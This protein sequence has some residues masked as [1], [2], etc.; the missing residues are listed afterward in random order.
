MFGSGD[1]ANDWTNDQK[2]MPRPKARQPERALP[3]ARKS[4]IPLLRFYGLNHHEL[5][6]GALVHELDAAADFGKEGVVFAATN[7]EAGFHACAALT[8]DDRPTGND[9]PAKCFK[10]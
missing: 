6:H 8:D 4:M 3:P 9:L 2:K 10:A 1:L 7:V 5:T